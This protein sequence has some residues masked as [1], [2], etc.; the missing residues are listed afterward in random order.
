MQ[1]EAVHAHQRG[2]IFVGWGG[3]WRREVEWLVVV[4]VVMLIL[5]VE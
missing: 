3:W 1:L 4:M 5:M 2:L